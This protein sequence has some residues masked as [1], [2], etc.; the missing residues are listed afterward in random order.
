[1][2]KDNNQTPV[3][4]TTNSDDQSPVFM[5]ETLPPMPQE[6]PITQDMAPV[7][8]KQDTKP[9]ETPVETPII[10]SGSAAPQDD[11]IMPPIVTSKN[12]KKFAGGKIIATILGLFL[13]IGGVGAGVFLVKQNQNINEK[14]SLA[15]GVEGNCLNLNQTC[16]EGLKTEADLDKCNQAGVQTGYKC[17]MGCANV[18]TCLKLYQTCCSGYEPY[19]DTAC[20]NV[21]VESGYKCKIPAKTPT[22]TPTTASITIPNNCDTQIKCSKG[23][24][25]CSVGNLFNKGTCY[26]NHYRCDK[27]A[28]GKGCSQYLVAGQATSASFNQSCGSEQIDLYCEA[29]GYTGSNQLEINTGHTY[30]C[31]GT[32]TTPP[33]APPTTPPTSA[34]GTASCTDIKVYT[35]QN[36]SDMVVWDVKSEASLSNFKAGDN[37]YFCVNGTSSSGSFDKARFNVNGNFLPDTTTKRPGSNDFCSLYTIPSGTTTFNITSQIHHTTLGWK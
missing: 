18:G 31:S 23:D 26:V 9:N 22:P 2:P 11:A 35:I 7:E 6:T 8:N 1:M 16:C 10:D 17:V 15:C 27:L 4:P 34:P 36:R 37:I 19:A 12:K 28:D 32:P 21:G 24:T 33:T 30:V 13:L 20:N 14:A 25:T 3:I 29:C 5:E